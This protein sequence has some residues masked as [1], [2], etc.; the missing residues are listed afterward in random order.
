MQMDAA[1][2]SVDDEDRAFKALGH[3]DR[4]AILR[5]IADD[6]EVAV[7]TLVDETELD[8]PIVSQHLRVLRDAGLVGVRVEGNRRLYSVQFARIGELRRFLDQFWNEKLAALKSVAED[9]AQGRNR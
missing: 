4:R 9:P 2:S 1:L 5:L 7:G 3:R 6:D 8:Q